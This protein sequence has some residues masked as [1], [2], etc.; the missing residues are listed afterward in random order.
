MSDSFFVKGDIIHFNFKDNY[1][2]NQHPQYTI[3]GPHFAVVLFDG[4][5]AKNT[6]TVAPITSLYDNNGQKKK[7]YPWDLEL[8][9]P[10][11]YNLK[12]PSYIKVDQI[13]TVDRK[14]IELCEDKIPLD[15]SRDIPKL[16]TCLIVVFELF[17]AIDSIAKAKLRKV[18]E[19]LLE[20]F[21]EKI[22][23]KVRERVRAEIIPQIYSS[24]TECIG[25]LEIDQE[26]REKVAEAL[27][28]D[29]IKDESNL[30]NKI[31]KIIKDVI[32]S[33]FEK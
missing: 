7:L 15:L 8:D 28:K 17:N 1:L 27:V 20:Q 18:N 16:E 33:L 5:A 32:K 30:S 6:I 26:V 3:K 29:H 10:E 25:V 9:P 22:L 19:V 4:G 11:L 13:H 14:S 12:K 24:M 2:P 21:D 23:E 31:S